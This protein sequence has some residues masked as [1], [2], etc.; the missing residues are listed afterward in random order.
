[1]VTSSGEETVPPVENRDK[2]RSSICTEA[3]LKPEAEGSLEG[4][5][6]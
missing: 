5:P 2:K 1:M 4:V 6:A 3:Q